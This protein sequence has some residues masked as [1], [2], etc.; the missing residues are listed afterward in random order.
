[1]QEKNTHGEIIP[2]NADKIV[3][4]LL[5]TSSGFFV[6]FEASIIYYFRA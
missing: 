3:F 1:M 4:L 6:Q 2:Y 5:N